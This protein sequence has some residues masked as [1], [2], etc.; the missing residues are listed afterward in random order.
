M[1][2]TNPGFD[3]DSRDAKGSTLRFI[4]VKGLGGAWGERGVTMSSTQFEFARD[5]KDLSWLYVVEFASDPQ[6]RKLWRIQDPAS[7]ANKF[8][9]DRGWQSAGDEAPPPVPPEA[10]LVPGAKWRFGN[11]EIGEITNVS[12]NGAFVK[13]IAIRVDGTIVTKSGAA[14]TLEM[15]VVRD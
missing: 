15:Q 14:H 3:I 5:Q 11:G 13:V 6:R 10:R 12:G 7:R 4:E 8:G 2:H 1:P 9:F